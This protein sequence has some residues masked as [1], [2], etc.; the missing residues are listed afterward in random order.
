MIQIQTHTVRP[1]YKY[2]VQLKKLPTG[3]IFFFPIT[4]PEPTLLSWMEQPNSISDIADCSDG[5][6]T[7][8]AYEIQPLVC[9]GK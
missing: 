9:T 1:H 2:T 6:T 5:A 4:S 3:F 7:G 8:E